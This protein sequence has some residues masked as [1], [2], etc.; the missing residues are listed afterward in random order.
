ML[1]VVSL[2]A[3]ELLGLVLELE[4]LGV[5]LVEEAVSLG[6][7]LLLMPAV[8]LVDEDELGNVDDV[9]E[10]LGLVE[11]ELGLLL[12]S[13]ELVESCE[14]EAVELVLLFD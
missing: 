7:V 5:V 14:V 10:E 3:T 1:R 11:V 6:V 2:E 13:A 4:V 8:V 12:A 9:E